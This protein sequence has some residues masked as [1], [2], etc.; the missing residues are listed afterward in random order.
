MELKEKIEKALR[1]HFQVEQIDLV[2]RDG[3][4]GIVVSPDFKGVGPLE[5][6]RRIARA[7]RDPSIKLSR[8]EQRRV[9]LIAPFTPVEFDLFGPNDEDS[10]DS[11]AGCGTRQSSPDLIPKV[12]QLL[13]SRF[14]VDHLRLGDEGG[15]YGSVVSPDFEGLSSLDRETLINRILRDPSSNLTDCER[16]RIRFIWM[17]TPAEYEAKREL[18][19]L[20]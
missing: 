20:D 14:R 8:G 18:D 5:R 16:D 15:I 11:L 19:A 10:D 17:Y 9:L 6:Q 2:D 3:I 1:S 4:S 13:R 12:E 7:L